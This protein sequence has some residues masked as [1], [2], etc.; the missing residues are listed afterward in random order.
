MA[1]MDYQHVHGSDDP[2]EDLRYRQRTLQRWRMSMLFSFMT[3]VLLTAVI[4]PRFNGCP[5]V[6]AIAA[7]AASN[8]PSCPSNSCPTCPACSAPDLSGTISRAMST[9]VAKCPQAPACPECKL[10]CPAAVQCPVPKAGVVTCPTC[11]SCPAAAAEAG[12]LE[13][14]RQDA[15]PTP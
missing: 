10:N 11:P 6:Q 3:G 1:G 13:C 8:C 9:A 15:R 14:A 12:G 4:F 5:N 2:H 7:A